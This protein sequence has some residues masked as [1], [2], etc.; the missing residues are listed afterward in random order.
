M[1]VEVPSGLVAF[2][3][4]VGDCPE[5]P[6]NDTALKNELGELPDVADRALFFG[7]PGIPVPVGSHE[8]FARSGIVAFK[9]FNP[10]LPIDGRIPADKTMF[11][12]DAVTFGG[13]SGGPVMR[14]LLPFKRKINLWGLITGGNLKGLDYAMVTSVERIKETIEFAV[15][16][17]TTANRNW[18]ITPP[19]LPIKCEADKK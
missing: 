6:I 11:Y 15:A 12:L 14:E 4:C 2:T 17:K 7:F 16:N 10:R 9:G 19:S 13:N 3:Y 8:P 1:K 18:T 5:N